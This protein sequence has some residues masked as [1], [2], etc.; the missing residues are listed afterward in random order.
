MLFLMHRILNIRRWGRIGVRRLFRVLRFIFRRDVW[1]YIHIFGRDRR[2]RI[3]YCWLSIIMI[4]AG[5]VAWRTTVRV[6]GG[7]PC[8]LAHDSR[9]TVISRYYCVMMCRPIQ[10]S[11][12]VTNSRPRRQ[13]RCVPKLRDWSRLIFVRWLC[14]TCQNFVG[15]DFYQNS[16]SF[17]INRLY[18]NRT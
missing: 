11:Q 17:S 8:H 6:P 1:S 18:A 14:I 13:S 3:H 4:R 15:L 16:N 5:R 10:G 9:I 7:S 12:P 2:S